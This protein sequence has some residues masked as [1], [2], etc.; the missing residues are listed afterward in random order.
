MCIDTP[1]SAASSGRSEQ[2]DTEDMDSS[3]T[4]NDNLMIVITG[5][6]LAVSLVCLAVLVG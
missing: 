1:I 5:V 2:K 6:L 4:V 3:T